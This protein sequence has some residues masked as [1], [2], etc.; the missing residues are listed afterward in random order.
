MWPFLVACNYYVNQGIPVFLLMYFK[1]LITWFHLI[2]ILGTVPKHRMYYISGSCH[3][4][5]RLEL[6]Y[7]VIRV[8]DRMCVYIVNCSRVTDRAVFN[9]SDIGSVLI[10]RNWYSE[11]CSPI[12]YLYAGYAIKDLLCGLVARVPSYRSRPR[13]RFPALPYFLRSSGSGTGCTQACED[14]WGATWKESS[15]S[16]VENWNW[17]PWGFVALTTRHTL[18]AKVGTNFANKRRSLGQYSSLA[19]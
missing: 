5:Q 6:M 9:I 10:F 13:V 17:R 14:N 19:D 8:H 7:T 11:K 3:T 12:L 15:G 2:S 4:K 1:H 16:G 18:S